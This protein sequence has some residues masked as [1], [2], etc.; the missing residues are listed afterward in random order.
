[1]KNE[2][3]EEPRESAKHSYSITWTDS[4]GLAHAAEFRLLNAS[5]SGVAFAS[6]VRLN[7]NTLVYVSAPEASTG[8]WALVRHCT[9]DGDEFVVGVELDVHQASSPEGEKDF[10]NFYEFLQIS[11][12][13][14][15]GTINRV[16]RY[17]AALYH[18]DNPT[19]GDA[20][21]FLQL[22]R[23]YRI[24]SSSE[25]RA[26]Y[27]AELA[28]R[29][30]EKSP[31]FDGVDFMDGV[32][33]ELNRRLAVLAVL[34][35]KCRSNIHES[36]VKLVELEQQ[37]GFPR[38]YLDFTT[39]Y[40]KNK[41]YIHKEDNSDFSLTA[42]GVDFVEENYANIPLLRR[43]LRSGSSP[44]FGTKDAGGNGRRRQPLI[45]PVPG[46]SSQDTTDE[47]SKGHS[48]LGLNDES[49]SETKRA[50]RPA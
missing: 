42:A 46:E 31:A 43:L 45:L 25:K 3:R 38:E 19:T 4:G 39:W 7:P 29:S 26:A 15:P 13:A 6:S 8:T 5:D 48:D 20:E 17:L 35:K 1:M 14:Q 33:G 27:D 47:A 36:R 18:P 49:S 50:R 10:E 40:L 12:A 23:A 24:L 21:Q 16:F 22:N 2:R 34:Y 9:P 30:G 44:E 41:K 28:R 11:P 32:E 37:M